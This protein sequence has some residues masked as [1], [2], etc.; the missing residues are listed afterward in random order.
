HV[1]GGLGGISHRTG[2]ATAIRETTRAGRDVALGGEDQLV[3]DLGVGDVAAD[4]TYEVGVGS[5]ATAAAGALT[6][7]EDDLVT[8]LATGDASSSTWSALSLDGV[9][10][11]GTTS[12]DGASTAIPINLNFGTASD[13][14]ASGD[15][16]IT[17]SR[18]TIVVHW[19]YV[20]T[21]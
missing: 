6:T 16:T 3:V 5:A 8:G 11:A 12:L 20:G 2:V 13:A 10:L 21:N 15:G 19:G 7:T 18:A 14:E 4:A 1:A 9:S 17:I